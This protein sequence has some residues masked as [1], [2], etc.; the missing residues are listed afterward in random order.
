[1]CVCSW[2]WCES[3]QV[4]AHMRA[5]MGEVQSTTS[6]FAAQEGVSLAQI[7]LSRLTSYKSMDP[8]V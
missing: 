6:V 3:V 1:M 7:S 2:M 8:P 4:A 5:N